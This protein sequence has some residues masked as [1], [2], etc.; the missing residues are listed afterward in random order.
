MGSANRKCL[1]RLNVRAIAIMINCVGSVDGVKII[2]GARDKPAGLRFIP[3]RVG[4]G[5]SSGDFCFFRV[6]VQEISAF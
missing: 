5:M 1:R 6:H 2:A 3:T 4:N